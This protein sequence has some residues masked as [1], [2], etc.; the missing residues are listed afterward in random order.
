[1]TNGDG[2]FCHLIVL[3]NSSANV[4]NGDGPFCHLIVLVNGSVMSIRATVESDGD[5][6]ASFIYCYLR[7]ELFCC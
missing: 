7:Y 4:T 2:P 3:V 5:G 6:D 1:M